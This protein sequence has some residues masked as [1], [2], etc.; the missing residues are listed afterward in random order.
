MG[1][2]GNIYGKTFKY[3]GKNRVVLS[4]C[5]ERASS[6]LA[7]RG[8]GRSAKGK[9]LFGKKRHLWG[10]GGTTVFLWGKGT[11]HPTV[12]RIRFVGG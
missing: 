7:T 8:D 10:G 2:L 5:K 4:P 6:V 3:K 12:R 1:D 9:N 11:R